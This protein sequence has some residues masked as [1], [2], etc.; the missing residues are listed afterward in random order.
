MNLTI[1][2]LVFD[3]ESATL[4]AALV[5]PYWSR[6][7]DP[8][9]D[10]TLHWALDVA[11]RDQIV[12]GMTWAPQVSHDWLRFSVR[13]WI[14]IQGQSIAWDVPF[15]GRTGKPNGS[16]CVFEHAEI[17]RASL[18][19]VERAGLKFRFEWEGLCDIDWGN[20]DGTG[21][22]FVANG[23]ATFTHIIVCGSEFDTDELLRAR[24]G[25]YVDVEDYIQEPTQR[26]GR[27]YEDGVKVASVLFKPILPASH[28]TNRTRV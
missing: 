22:P 4:G 23:W 27:S 10:T 19:F 5:D 20:D 11:T 25:R 16:F 2:D 21:V 13:R 7:Y 9:G 1:K 17:S 18:R 24:L 14:D 8:G 28:G 15:D 26:P 12:D 3:I 6:K